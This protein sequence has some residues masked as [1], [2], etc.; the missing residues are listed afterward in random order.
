MMFSYRKTGRGNKSDHSKPSLGAVGHSSGILGNHGNTP[1]AVNQYE[2]K[3]TAGDLEYRHLMPVPTAH[4]CTEISSWPRA[5]TDTLSSSPY[6]SPAWSREDDFC[7]ID[8]EDT[9]VLKAKVT[10]TKSQNPRGSVRLQAQQNNSN[11]NKY[12]AC[13]RLSTVLRA[14]WE[15]THFNPQNIPVR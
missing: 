15:L 1:N 4:V 13:H 8:D 5:Y 2:T 14:L 12:G 7:L 6:N 10:C 11:N 3:N 9:R